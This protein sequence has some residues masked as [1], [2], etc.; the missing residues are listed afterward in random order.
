MR[1]KVK[2]KKNVT[3][4]IWFETF[5]D[6]KEIKSKSDRICVH[7]N[8]APLLENAELQYSLITELKIDIQDVFSSFN[9]TVRNEIRRAEREGTVC[10]FFTSEDLKN[11]EKLLDDFSKMYTEMYLQK[12]LDR[13]LPINEIRSY[14]ESYCFLLTVAYIGDKPCVYH[15]YIFGDET[16]RLLHS[17]SEFRAGDNA[18]RNAIGRANKLLHWIDM[19]YLKNH[20]LK[21]Y[22]WGGVANPNQP[23]G[24]DKF[25]ISFGG[26]IISYYNFNLSI[27]MK[28][29]IF[30]ALLKLLK[31]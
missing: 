8:H 9:A 24:I 18:V 3:E 7:A 25:K 28:A 15:S 23:N 17:C 22:D 10:K 31:R 29:K 20:G 4:Q 11:N 14:I 1:I 21:K 13:T 27:S 12:N 19:G 5:N 6:I 26:E 16:A 30:D 2:G